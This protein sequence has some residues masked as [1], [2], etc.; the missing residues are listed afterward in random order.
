VVEEAQANQN[1]FAALNYME[2]P[3]KKKLSTHQQQYRKNWTDNRALTVEGSSVSM[4]PLEILGNGGPI[5]VGMCNWIVP[6]T[7]V[8]NTN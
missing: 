1:Q 4:I 5:I 2:N 6:L 7:T 8:R 3:T